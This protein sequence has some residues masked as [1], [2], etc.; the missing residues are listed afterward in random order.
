MDDEGGATA[1]ARVLFRPRTSLLAGVPR[2]PQVGGRERVGRTSAGK[3]E[4]YTCGGVFCWGGEGMQGRECV[5][6]CVCGV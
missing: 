4:A 5:F 3:L 6:L 2:L 1:Y